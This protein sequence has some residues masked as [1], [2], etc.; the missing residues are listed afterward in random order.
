MRLT[1]GVISTLLL[2]GTISLVVSACSSRPSAVRGASGDAAQNDGDGK[3]NTPDGKP[4]DLDGDGIADP[5]G[6]IIVDEN[7]NR[8]LLTTAFPRLSHLQWENSV[9]DVLL[10]SKAPGLSADFLAD[11]PG[12]I[13]GNDSS[14]LKVTPN[15]WSDYQRAAEKVASDLTADAAAVKKLLPASLPA[16]PTQ[17]AKA[18]IEPIAKRA[19]RRPPTEAEMNG[20]ADLFSKGKDFTGK[21]DA[22]TAGLQVAI[23]A[24]LQSP[25]FLYRPEL[26]SGQTGTIVNLNGYEVA[27]RLS[28]AVW[29][30]IPDNTLL[31]LAASGELMKVAV[32][33]AQAERLMKD[34]RAS[35]ALTF[36][37]KKALHIDSFNTIVAKDK[38]LY[39]EWSADMNSVLYKEA[40]LFIKDVVD[41]NNKGVNEILTAPYTFV[42]QTNAPLYGLN[43]SGT[44]MKKVQLDDAQRAGFLTQVGFLA[45]NSTPRE[46]DPIHRGVFS[47]VNITCADLIPPPGTIP[48]LPKETT[49]KTMRERVEAHTGKGTCGG[50]C[51]GE[52][53]NP[54]GYAFENFD[55]AGRWRTTDSG[56][57]ID[58]ASEYSFGGSLMPFDG[59]VEFAKGLAGRMEVHTCFASKALELIYGRVH[60]DG[61]K[62][63]IKKLATA[64]LA[65]TSTKDI[66][67]QLLVDPKVTQRVNKD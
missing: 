21:A 50:S 55:A 25:S 16:N 48:T 66:F 9:R 60:D 13:F 65:G 30:T 33:K 56:H 49:A 62:A 32:Q 22:T 8:I 36:F 52:R 15:L 57:P 58:A 10:L 6:E 14:L 38:T 18:I 67:L 29:N 43:A 31:D 41:T 20:L 47:S 3:A 2:T 11:P 5:P 1:A 51:H 19:F 27:S 37:Y 59:P 45:L 26:G 54:A 63:L 64:S 34:V 12:S 61:D 35:E 40:E 24:I 42:N 39:P 23:S 28:Y 46:T 4:R 53:I 17:L 7:G 44:E